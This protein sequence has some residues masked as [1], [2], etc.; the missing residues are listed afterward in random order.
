VRLWTIGH[1]NRDFDSVA[2][3]LEHHGVQTIV[4]V[5]SRPYSRYATEFVKTELAQAAAAAGLG[6][7]WLGDKLGG[8]PAAAPT[9]LEAGIDEL[10]GLC[11]SSRVVLLCS[12]VDPTH[13]H[14]DTVLAPAMT[15]RSF[16]VIHILGDGTATP[17][18]DH[19]HLEP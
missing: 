17:H 19:L 18:Q 11:A 12:E 7:R 2:A 15:Q 10:A 8:K 9:E 14:R 4:D 13:C 6:Y 1:G 16:E 3:A 5:R